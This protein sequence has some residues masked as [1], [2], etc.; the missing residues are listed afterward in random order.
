MQPWAG[1]LVIGSKQ[2][3]TRSWNTKHRGV[4]AV[5][6]SAK[7]PKE[8]YELLKWLDQTIPGGKWAPGG[9]YYNICTQVSAVLGEVEITNTYPS[10]TTEEVVWFADQE[11]KD[12]EKAL[13][14]WSPGRWLWVCENPVIYDSPIY[15]K[16]KLQIWNWNSPSIAS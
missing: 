9:E 14:D 1:L 4:I 8:G 15:E 16:G 6:A 12:F 11:D 7:I 10:D 5:H 2:V 13:G 3:E